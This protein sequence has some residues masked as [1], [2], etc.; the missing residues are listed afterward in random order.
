MAIVAKRLPIS[1]IAE[2][3][4]HRDKVERGYTSS[5]L[6]LGLS[7]GIKSVSVCIQTP[8]IWPCRVQNLQRSKAWRSDKKQMRNFLYCPLRHIHQP[9]QEACLWVNLAPLGNTMW[10]GR[11]GKYFDYNLIFSARQTVVNY[12]QSHYWFT[13]IIGLLYCSE[14]IAPSSQAIAAVAPLHVDKTRFSAIYLLNLSVNCGAVSIS[15]HVFR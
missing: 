5:N 10:Q 12:G 7:D 3:L 14:L 9:W 11:S 2:L 15:P 13:E 1:A 4:R 8:W 6:H